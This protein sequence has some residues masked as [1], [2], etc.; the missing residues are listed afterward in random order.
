M[1][2]KALQLLSLLPQKPGEF[3]DRMTAIAEVRWEASRG[4]AAE[5]HVLEAQEGIRVL[6]CSLGFD[7]GARLKETALAGVETRIGEG[8][9]HVP[10]DAPFGSFH[11]GDSLLGR[12]CYAT[13]RA[14][15]PMFVVETG[16]CYGVTS[17]YLL[18]ALEVN[19]EGHLHSIDLPPL[20]K[21]GDSYVGWLVPKEL[22]TR[23]TLHQ[24]A[25]RRLLGPLLAE[26]GQIDLFIHDSLHTCGNMKREFAAAWPA[27]R[28][29]GVLISDDVEG[30]GAFLEL[31]QREDVAFSVVIKER[32]KDAL[33]GVAVKQA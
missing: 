1:V 33:L 17:S 16:V 23:W 20:G 14:L 3:Y 22:R 32:D 4:R 12:I 21:N 9:A 25:S 30:N 8:Q 18:Q 5:Y 31:V 11:N 19:E 13:A 2:S 7:C 24:G 28:A 27:L 26:L 10:R 6:S 15:R 29:G